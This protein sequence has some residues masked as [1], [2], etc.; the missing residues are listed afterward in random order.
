MGV[1]TGRDFHVV[2]SRKI[3]DTSRRRVVHL[4]VVEG[5][6]ALDEL[7]RRFKV[8]LCDASRLPACF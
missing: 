6:D 7:M 4:A 3:P 5:F 1:D 2:I 8:A